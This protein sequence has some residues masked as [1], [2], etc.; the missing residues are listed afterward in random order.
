MRIA[1]AVVAFGLLLSAAAQAAPPP[2][3]RGVV[4]ATVTRTACPPGEP[5]D[6]HPAGA[7]VMFTR[8]TRLVARA[9]VVRG[10]FALHL[11][12]G[13]YGVRL[14]PPPLGGRV[15]PA[16][17]LVPRAGSVTLRFTVKRVTVTA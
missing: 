15:V 8:G 13:R 6:P 2:N 16:T 10:A 5:C 17:V 9:R 7:Y 1:V 12:P 11:V 14:V 3:V 4:S